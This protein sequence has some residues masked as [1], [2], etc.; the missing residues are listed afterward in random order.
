MDHT[1]FTSIVWESSDYAEKHVGNH[2][3]CLGIVQR[4]WG[5]SK[6]KA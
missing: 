5:A 6:W 4:T 3:V 1:T 2:T